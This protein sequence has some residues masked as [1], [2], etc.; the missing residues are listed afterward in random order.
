MLN[1]WRQLSQG[2]W[3]VLDCIDDGHGRRF[4][5]ARFQRSG[6]R[7][8]HRLSA[9]ERMVVAAVAA[10]RSNREIAETL[11]ISVSSVAGYLRAARRKLGGPRRVDLVRE[12]SSSDE[13]CTTQ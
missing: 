7:P 13:R 2:Q 6:E 11:G 1:T 5:L 9:R 10:G 4:I 8:W 12:W 3:V